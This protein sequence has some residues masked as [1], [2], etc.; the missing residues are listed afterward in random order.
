MLNLAIFGP[1][2]CG[3]GTQSDFLI[4][5]YGL[6]HIS[7]GD[8]LRNEITEK[9]DIGLK[10]KSIID[11]GLLVGD[12]LVTQL[13]ERRIEKGAE[14]G[15]LFDGFPRTTLQC[16]ILDGILAN[17]NTSL[18]AL[19]NLE[20]PEVI[21]IQRLL[22]RA[23]ISGRSD[24]NEETIIR[25]LQEF[26]EKTLPVIDYYKKRNKVYNINGVGTIPEIEQKVQKQLESII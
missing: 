22:E 19:I 6:I 10:A 18:K 14:K 24:D 21:L 20:T 12:D 23:K 15:F 26:K 7:M 5:K 17:N 1:P 4:Q 3:K 16:Y 25:R 8:L 13:I 2:G 9:T 11:Q